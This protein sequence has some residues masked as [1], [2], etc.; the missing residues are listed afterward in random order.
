M[1]ILF[2]KLEQMFFN[3]YL[4]DSSLITIS[5]TSILSLYEKVYYICNYKDDYENGIITK[6]ILEY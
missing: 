3:N 5:S 6:Y 1:V 2:K 4:I